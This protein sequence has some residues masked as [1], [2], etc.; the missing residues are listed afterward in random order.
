MLEIAETMKIGRNDEDS[1]NNAVCLYVY[2][3]ICQLAA[4]L[5]K[6]MPCHYFPDTDEFCIRAGDVAVRGV[7]KPLPRSM[8]H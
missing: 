6:F 1:K 5:N 3:I 2:D 8:C 4:I 7:S